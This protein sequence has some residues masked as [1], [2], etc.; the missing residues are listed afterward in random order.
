[1]TTEIILITH[2]KIGMAMLSTCQEIF[3]DHPLPLTTH[4]VEVHSG[5]CPDIIATKLEP[6]TAAAE[7]ETKFLVLT[8]IF[9]ATPCNTASKIFAKLNATLVSGLN[10]AMLLRVYSHPSLS[11]E[12]LTDKAVQG[13]REGIF[14]LSEC[15]CCHD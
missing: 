5:D 1:M 6:I 8:D 11:F 12:E 4:A 13:G 7:P 10:L 14:A 15:E 2:D 9:G 3:G